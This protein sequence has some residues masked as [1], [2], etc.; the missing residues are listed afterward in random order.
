MSAMQS[1]PEDV[2]ACA[3]GGA[4]ARAELGL[5]DNYYDTSAGQ[6]ERMLKT[7]EKLDKTGDRI[8]QGRAQLA[9]TEA[10]LSSCCFAPDGCGTCQHQYERDTRRGRQTEHAPGSGSILSWHAYMLWPMSAAIAHWSAC[11]L[12]VNCLFHSGQSP[13]CL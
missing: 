4:A 10:S 1:S 9:E 12:K 2:I 11:V 6:R 3:T 5:A 7:T 8:S 13:L